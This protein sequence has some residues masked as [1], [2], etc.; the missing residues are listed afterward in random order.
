VADA[1]ALLAQL[2]ALPSHGG[3]LAE[4]LVRTPVVTGFALG[5]GAPGRPSAVKASFT[6]AGDDSRPFVP[7]FSSADANLAG[8]AAE[9][10]RVDQGAKTNV[11]NPS[12]VSGVLAFGEQTGMSAIRIGRVAIPIDRHGRILAHFTGAAPERFRPA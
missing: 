11:V 3:I 5:N 10:L 4:V 8:L 12:G 2:V 1:E 6:S 9:A 7:S